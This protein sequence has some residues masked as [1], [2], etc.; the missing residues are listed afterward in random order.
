VSLPHH[1][2]DVEE[3]NSTHKQKRTRT[4]QT[5]TT[6][7]VHEHT[8]HEQKQT[9]R[10]TYLRSVVSPPHHL[11]D[12]EELKSVDLIVSVFVQQLVEE[13]SV[14]VSRRLS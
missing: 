12:V 7:N 8:K 5:R 3:K 11:D 14:L 4:H 6:N 13:K 9:K 1:L 10:E 2:D